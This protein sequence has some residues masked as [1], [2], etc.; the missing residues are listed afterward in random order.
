MSFELERFPEPEELERRSEELVTVELRGR[1]LALLRALQLRTG[2]GPGELI[3]V[4]LLSLA[5]PRGR[6]FGAERGRL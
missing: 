5:G 3:R 1:E 2:L 6:M 4:S